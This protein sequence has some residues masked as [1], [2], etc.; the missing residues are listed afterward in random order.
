MN[1]NESLFAYESRFVMGSNFGGW[2]V[3]QEM[4]V[5]HFWFPDV[6]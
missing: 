5:I 2:G 6:K 4:S 3:M 1:I